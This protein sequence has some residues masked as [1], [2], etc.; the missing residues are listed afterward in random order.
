MGTPAL[1][2]HPNEAKGRSRGY[3]TLFLDLTKNEAKGRSREQGIKGRAQRILIELINFKLAVKWRNEGR[4][5]VVYLPYNSW[6]SNLTS[7]PKGSL[8]DFQFFASNSYIPPW[9]EV[10]LHIGV[11]L[12]PDTN[13]QDHTPGR[14]I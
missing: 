14:D 4:Y 10:V 5:T 8:Q 9:G 1:G 12:R 7:D 11:G 6:N 13:V 3:S 2:C